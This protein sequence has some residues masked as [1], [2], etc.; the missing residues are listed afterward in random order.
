MF[1]AD[2]MSALSAM[3]DIVSTSVRYTG[4]YRTKFNPN[5]TSQLADARIVSSPARPVRVGSSWSA[6]SVPLSASASTLFGGELSKEFT[7]VVAVASLLIK[8]VKGQR[9][10]PQPLG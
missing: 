7:E 8:N 1:G 4:R 5:Q 2:D 6:S 9:V 3:A 10:F